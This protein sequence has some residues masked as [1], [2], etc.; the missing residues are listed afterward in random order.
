MFAELW[1]VGSSN[2]LGSMAFHK[3]PRHCDM[4][5][6]LHDARDFELGLKQQTVTFKVYLWELAPWAREVF[7]QAPP[8]RLL[9]Y[10]TQNHLLRM[11]VGQ[12]S[13]QDKTVWGRCGPREGFIDLFIGSVSRPRG[14]WSSTFNTLNDP[15]SP[16][17]YFSVNYRIRR[18]IRW[19]MKRFLSMQLKDYC[20]Y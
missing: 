5:R 7:H 11:E 14:T 15:E 6:G 3:F 8:A 20:H 13:L 12:W 2:C 17:R 1:K 18:S 19:Q 9:L 16:P 10:R 4:L